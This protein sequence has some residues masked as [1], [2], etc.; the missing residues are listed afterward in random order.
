MKITKIAK[1][2]KIFSIIFVYLMYI[3]N[4]MYFLSVSK[5]FRN[6]IK[7]RLLISRC[8]PR[9][10]GS[11]TGGA[12]PPGDPETAEGTGPEHEGRAEPAITG[13]E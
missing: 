13:E 5:R 8:I 4:V 1:I 9:G 11:S 3:S 7:V 6:S 2:E 12:H 10:N